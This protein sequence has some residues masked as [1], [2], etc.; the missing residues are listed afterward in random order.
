MYKN[1]DQKVLLNFRLPSLVGFFFVVG[2]AKAHH[3]SQMCV[4]RFPTPLRL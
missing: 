4:S 2:V 1:D 3:A